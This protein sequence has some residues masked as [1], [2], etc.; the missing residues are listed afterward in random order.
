M[1][2]TL[3][4]KKK[5][6]ALLNAFGNKNIK[7]GKI[8]S[9]YQDKPYQ[10]LIQA[11]YNIP[12]IQKIYDGDILTYGIEKEI[13]DRFKNFP[14][15]IN[16]DE[17]ET[18]ASN[19]QEILIKNLAEHLIIVPIPSAKF[20]NQI[21]I[22]NLI[23]IP[24]D[25]SRTDKLKIIAKFAKKTI[26]ETNWI[27]DH[28]EKSRSP[29]FLKYPL[30]CIKQTEHTS[31]IHY[32]ALNIAKIVIY[33]I[34]CFYFGNIYNSKKDR[35][36]ILLDFWGQKRLKEASHLAIYSKE[37]WR[38]N[39]KPL[40]FDVSL[41]YDLNW[42]ED[43]ELSNEFKLFIQRIYFKGNLDDFNLSFLNSLILYNESIKQNNSISTIITMTIGESILTR[44]RNEKRLRIAAITPRL[45]NFPKNEQKSISR[46][47]DELYQKRNNFVHSGEA[48]SINYDFETTEPN[49]LETVRQTM[50]KLILEFPEFEKI[51]ENSIPANDT[52]NKQIIRMKY[53]ERYVDSIF[54]D[55]IY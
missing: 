26:K 30:L 2:L 47:L 25:Y 7:D 15:V 27:V 31:T 54:Q 23:L 11:L 51:V 40:N 12:E 39:H 36:T 45:L 37:N 33:S 43:K 6:A 32:S 28:T 35:T 48:V 16:E 22:D 42:L 41:P 44:N 49:L 55:I 46:N 24:E 19:L 20:C 17:A 8:E 38:Q 18:I 53:W 9:D 50:A 4:D 14:L 21:K 34:R 3:S 1:N 29:D 5:L 13:L 52:T 10:N